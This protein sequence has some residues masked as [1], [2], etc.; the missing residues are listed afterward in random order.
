VI[1][2]TVMCWGCGDP[3]LRHEKDEG[4]GRGACTVPGCP[5]LGF[6][7]VDP[8]PAPPEPLR[9]PAGAS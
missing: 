6:R 9:A 2:P 1:P 7:W 5:C 3:F 8:Q 4:P